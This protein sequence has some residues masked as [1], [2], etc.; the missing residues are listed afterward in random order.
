M[1]INKKRE[2]WNFAVHDILGEP[3]LYLDIIVVVFFILAL[4]GLIT[5]VMFVF[6][7]CLLFMIL[8][9]YSEIKPLLGYQSLVN[10]YFL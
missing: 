6:W 5:E 9:M 3:L 8:R 7:I 4:I 2:G 1:K 10:V